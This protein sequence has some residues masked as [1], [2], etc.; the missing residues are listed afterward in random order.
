[1][2]TVLLWSNWVA[3]VLC[4]GPVAGVEVAPAGPRLDREWVVVRTA[5]GLPH[6]RV[7]CLLVA[8]DDVWVGTPHGL[9]WYHDGKWQVLTTAD[10]L[11]H[12]AVSALALDTASGDLWIGT[13]GGLARRSGGRIQ[14][15]GQ[16]D[17]GLANDVVY[18]LAAHRGEVWIGT[19]AGISRYEPARDRWQIY[20]GSN[21]PVAEMW[22]TS[23]AARENDFYV[24]TNG[25]GLLRFDLT[26]ERWHQSTDPDRD[27]RLDLL[28]DDGLLHDR[29]TAVA[30]DGA[31]RA[32]IGTP[33]GLCLLDGESW[34]T[35]RR[36]DG[37]LAGD[38]VYCIHVREGLVWVG[39]DA[40]LSV[41][42]SERWWTPAP[43]GNH[44]GEAQF[45]PLPHPAVLD[46]AFRGDEIWIATARGLVVGLPHAVDANGAVPSRS[47]AEQT[48]ALG[49]AGPRPAPGSIPPQL[50][51]WTALPGGFYGDPADVFFAAPA[52]ALPGYRADTEDAAGSGAAIRIGV[53]APLDETD[54]G[55]EGREMLAGV[56]LAA[57]RFER[58]HPN[59]PIELI[60][61]PSSGLWGA[62]SNEVVSLICDERVSVII[63][64]ID[65][66]DSHIALQAA[67]ALGVPL[68]NPA[69]GDPALTEMG[70]PWVVRTYP[71][72]R[73]QAH[74]LA[75]HVYHQLGI[76]AVGT[77]RS[78]N[79]FG[80]VGVDQFRLAAERLG[81]PV[82][83]ELRWSPGDRDFADQLDRFARVGVRAIV[84]WGPAADCA[85]IVRQSRQ[86]GDS[87]TFVCCDRVVT[88]EF[89][90]AAGP[91][92]EGVVA[93]ATVDPAHGGT[94]WESFAVEFL[95][96]QEHSPGAVAA[97]AFD[98]ASLLLDCIARSGGDPGLLRE[99]LTDAKAWNGVGGAFAIDT[100]G[101]HAGPVYVA[102]YRDGAWRYEE[103]DLARQP[104]QTEVA[105]F[106]R[107]VRQRPAPDAPAPSELV[108][109]CLL[110]LDESGRDFVRGATLAV[111][112]DWQQHPEQR[113]VSFHARDGRADWVRRADALVDLATENRVRALIMSLDGREEALA[114]A[115]ALTYP[116]PVLVGRQ[117]AS[118]AADQNDRLVRFVPSEVDAADTAFV[119]A[120]RAEHKAEPG[121]AAT[122]GYTVTRKVIA[123][124]REGQFDTAA[125]RER[126]TDQR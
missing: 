6:D 65:G 106:E 70:F 43:P 26:R 103:F 40:G 12:A 56:R 88:P 31:G 17:S 100:T 46:V 124:W 18:S 13:F 37:G 90:E 99:A 81:E 98:G 114:T 91:A 20:E 85:A 48:Q 62:S 9:G 105:V 67:A 42:D 19:A 111:T 58:A 11:P 95:E 71:D 68:V 113:P 1:M 4:A 30:V 2:R 73:R 39:T 47:P 82:R 77:F 110:P 84:L 34:R 87:F 112:L 15:F 119:E 89:L 3:L 50:N 10:G 97:H 59:R 44:P 79:R 61:R 116:V 57:R 52:A 45:A 122:T 86:R 72:A 118:G 28:R 96:T 93:A 23:L 25:S 8:G 66:A 27:D 21:S 74:A 29:V 69:I 33:V 78:N 51:P 120:W 102:T 16:L 94:A 5:D 38:Q 115:F 14:R 49:K 41:T 109:G 117:T 123:A 76:G 108:I 121:A 35:F 24:G 80:E 126:L 64:T 92:A 125:L 36:A 54:A 83:F 60:V 101:N 7:N 55:M 107:M 63:G 104:R 22:C 53:L 32:W 75:Q